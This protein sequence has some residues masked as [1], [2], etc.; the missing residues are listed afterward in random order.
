[1]KKFGLLL[2]LILAGIVYSILLLY[3]M[4]KPL[5]HNLILHCVIM[6]ILYGVT[7]FI[8]FLIYDKKFENIKRINQQLKFSLMNDNLTVL[9]NRRA[10]D[11]DIKKIKNNGIY[12]TIFLDVDNFRDFNNHFGHAAGDMVLKEVGK[13]IKACVRVTDRVYRYGG[14][15]IVMLLLDCDKKNAVKMAEKIRLEIARI[16]NPKFP[17]ITVSIGVASYPDDG[18]SIHEVIAASDKALL[19]AKQCGKNCTISN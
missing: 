6:G 4:D 5:F 13:T 10:F 15:E 1:M 17:Q 11:H 8:I 19:T 2:A 3:F 12:S 16:D 14:E 18:Q 7:N 9:L